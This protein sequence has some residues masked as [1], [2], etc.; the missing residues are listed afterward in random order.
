MPTVTAP[1]PLL[2]DALRR[3]SLEPTEQRAALVGTVVT[4]EL[5]L[6]LDNAMQA[7]RHESEMAGVTLD[8]EVQASLWRLNGLLDAQRGNRLW[9]DAAL[10]DHPTWAEARIVARQVLP[11]IPGRSQPGGAI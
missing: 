5:A 10:D 11:L 1:F 3:L 4:D 8:P 9:T 2:R 6:D 7:L